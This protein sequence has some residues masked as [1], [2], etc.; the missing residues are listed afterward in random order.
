MSSEADHRHAIV[1]EAVTTGYFVGEPVLSDLTCNV[2]RVGLTHL[3]GPNGSG[4]STFVELCSGYLR[5]W[6]GSVRIAG[7][8]AADRAA[9]AARRVCRTK[10]ALYPRMTVRDHL[11]LAARCASVSPRLAMERADRLGVGQWMDA[12][13]STLSTGNAR[14]LWY[15]MCTLGSFSVVVLDEPFVGLDHGGV[16]QV[17]NDVR[18]WAREGAVVLVSHELPPAI[19]PDHALELVGGP[20]GARAQPRLQHR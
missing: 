15:L 5:P 14:K 4:K 6:A 18:V 16:Q 13:A 10:P 7:H 1:I 3:R 20:L 12:E 17:C 2:M 8:E 19:Y 9:R 11:H